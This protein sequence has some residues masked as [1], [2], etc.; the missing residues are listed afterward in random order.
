MTRKHWLGALAFA[1]LIAVSARFTLALPG[2]AVPQTLQTIAVLLCGAF[3]GFNAASL[4]VVVYLLAGFVGLPVF[5]DGSSGARVLFGPSGGYLLAFWFCAALLGLA[6]DKRWLRVHF[7]K[8]CLWMLAGHAVILVVG[9]GLLS[10]SVGLPA[11]WFNGF[12]PYLLGAV[13]KSVI[14]AAVVW[15][16]RV[17]LQRR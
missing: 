4:A 17:M 7:W 2:S 12:E 3:L 1:V 10:I 6:A 9:A 8:L 16:S 11:A 14:A 13:V 15:T 5:A